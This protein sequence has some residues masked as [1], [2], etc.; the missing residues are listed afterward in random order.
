MSSKKS[1]AVYLLNSPILTSYGRWNFTGPLTVDQTRELLADGFQSAVGHAASATFLSNLLGVE[2]PCE[3]IT[4]NLQPGDRAV[5][6]RLHAR[7][8]EGKILTAEEMAALPYELGLLER[9]D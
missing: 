8:P 2:V 3:R 6:L 9:L 1:N 4:V 5:V 7:L